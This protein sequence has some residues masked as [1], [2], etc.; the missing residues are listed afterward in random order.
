MKLL[1]CLLENP[2]HILSGLV[3]D[4]LAA[5]SSVILYIY[6]YNQTNK[7]R[8]EELTRINKLEMQ[9]QKLTELTQ[10]LHAMKLTP[11]EVIEMINCAIARL[12]KFQEIN[13]NLLSQ[14]QPLEL[15]GAASKPEQIYLSPREISVLKF[16][17]QGKSNREIATA[18]N[19]KE[20]Y[21][22]ST[23]SRLYD[24]LDIHDRGG[25]AVYAIKAGY[26]KFGPQ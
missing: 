3:S 19:L 16:V 2:H 5:S 23:V 17:G 13:L 10:Q 4:W 12:K 20:S 22:K 15:P 26:T 18:L 14:I 6:I 8:E 21:I 9:N 25:L 1:V 11:R 7:E 24:K